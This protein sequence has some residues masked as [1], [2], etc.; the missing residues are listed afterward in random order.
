MPL[1]EIKSAQNKLVK[2]LIKL[3]D[4]K[5]YRK[6]HN[7]VLIINDK[8]IKDVSKKITP[9][10]LF[11][12]N[13]KITHFKE[14]GL[15]NI[16]ITSKNIIKKIAN[17]EHPQ[18][19]VAVFPLPK[20]KTLKNQK[21]LLLLDKISNPGNLGT[22]IRSAYAFDFDGVIISND[23]V[24]PFNDKAI[25]SAKEACFFM[26]IFYMSKDKIIHLSQDYPFYLADLLG[27]NF[28][29]V[30]YPKKL[31]LIVSNEALGPSK[32]LET[33]STKVNIPTNKDIDSLNV[34]IAGSI[35]MQKIS[36]I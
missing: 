12:T 4:D 29:K 9:L 19:T 23:C 7:Q 8:I 2:H 28:E 24:D 34:S 20:N 33:I 36:S 22:L 1:K 21:K 5:S 26:P 18:E 10:S 25:R 15:S 6:K 14:V 13:N 31:C 30:R 3:R 32:Y 16:Y 35:I 11:S 17:V 27:K